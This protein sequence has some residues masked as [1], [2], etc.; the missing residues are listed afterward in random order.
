MES[1]RPSVTSLTPGSP[2]WRWSNPLRW[3]LVDRTLTLVGVTLLFRL[4]NE[5]VVRQ[6]VSDPGAGPFVDVAGVAG[7]EQRLLAIIGVW[8]V[9]GVVGLAIR[10]RAP[11]SRAYV[12]MCTF[13]FWISDAVMGYGMGTLAPAFWVVVLGTSVLMILAFGG[14]YTYPGMFAAGVALVGTSIAERMHLIRYA[15]IFARAPYYADGRPVGLWYFAMTSTSIAI[16]VV[17]VAGAHYL[18]KRWREY[19]E[20]LERLSQTDYLTGLANRRFFRERCVAELARSRR[21]GLSVALLLIDVDFF[22]LV[23]DRHGHQ[24]GDEVLRA[25]ASTLQ[26]AVR[27]EDL[28]SRY[29]GEEFAVLLVETDI[30]AA[31]RVAERFRE[32]LASLE[33][34]TVAG[35]VK[36]TATAGVVASTITDMTHL[37]DLL[38]AADE[39]LYRGKSGGR[40]RVERAAFTAPPPPARAA[41]AAQAR[42]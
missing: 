18:V 15:P 42:Q 8:V 2:R 32:Q 23:N 26:L 29:G 1:S 30:E 19:D 40:N 22:K 14:R 10:R 31:N 9:L 3:S 35:P 12:H 25:I 21:A 7:F 13:Y 17:V 33:I 38:R 34:D 27:T 5:A 41:K 28:V 37:D 4:F 36:V 16:A 20:R 11:N 6:I 24:A 39:A